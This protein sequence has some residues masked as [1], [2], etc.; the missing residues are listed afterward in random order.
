MRYQ[1]LFKSQ[2]GFQRGR[3]T[4]QAT[5]D[6]LKTVKNAIE[7][8]E[9]AICILDPDQI[10]IIGMDFVSHNYDYVY[11]DPTVPVFGD[12]VFTKRPGFSAIRT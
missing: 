10:E 6:F 5:M 3:N 11:H 1:I 7:N 2:Y 9:F 8:E 4:T 12:Q